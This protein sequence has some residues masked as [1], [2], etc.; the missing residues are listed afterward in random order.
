MKILSFLASLLFPNA[1]PFCDKPLS[2][3]ELACPGCV[4]HLPKSTK[5]RELPESD[6]LCLFP[7]FYKGTVRRAIL[8]MKF[9]H[10]T[11]N[12]RFFALAL[13]ETLENEGNFDLMIPVPG[14]F[15]VGRHL[16]SLCSL[17]S[18]QT[19]IP[20]S[21]RILKRRFGSKK[22]HKLTMER[23]IENAKN[24]YHLHS[25]RDLSNLR[26]LLVDDII[27]TGATLNTCATLLKKAGAKE[28]V[29]LTIASTDTIKDGSFLSNNGNYSFHYERSVY[30]ENHTLKTLQFLTETLIMKNRSNYARITMKMR[31]LNYAGH[32]YQ[33]L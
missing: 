19:K 4:R 9:Q 1:C 26:I 12:A 17:L 32:R 10:R 30:Y 24:S 20:L 29:C 15:S 13:Q 18:K 27:T 16:S 31:C 23:R 33:R 25:K 28:I 22:Q 7:Y 6:C 2:F 3:E 5:K 21:K 8:A 14:V 11:E